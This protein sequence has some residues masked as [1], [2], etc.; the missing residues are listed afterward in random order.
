MQNAN[1]D[2]Q[3]A[4]EPALKPNSEL[5]RRAPALD[6]A[7]SETAPRSQREAV[8]PPQK[9]AAAKDA[10]ASR[11]SLFGDDAPPAT[12]PKSPPPASRDSLF[13][14]DVPAAAKPKPE[15]KESRDSLFGS[16]APAAAAPKPA[17]A[18]R[19]FV[20][21]EAAYGF[22]DPA[23]WTKE[24]LRLELNRQ[25]QFSENV[26]WKIGGRFDYDAA[27]D[28]SNFYAPQV[29]QDQRYGFTL[30]ENYLDISS[31]NLEMRLGR[32]HVVWG[33]VVGFFVADVVSAKDQREFIL[34]E[35]EFEMLRIPQWAAR[36]EYF[37]K[38]MKAEL[39][40]IPVPSFDEIG[41]PGIPGVRGAAGADFF[42]YPIPGPGGT[43]FLGEVLPSAKLANTNYGARM[44]TLKSGW[45][46]SA[47][48]YHSL[49]SAPTFYRNVI[50]GP[51]PV[52][53]YQARHDRINQFGGTFAKDLGNMV[54]K[55]EAVYTDGRQF[56]VTRI[57][58]PNGLV[59]QKTID[60]VLGLDFNLPA[61]ARLN[62]QFF[63][64]VFLDHDPDTLQ[65][66]Y[67]SGVSVLFDAVK[68]GKN[69]EGRALLIHSLNR[70]DWLLR[71]KVT[72]SFQK[73]WRWALGV[74]I[75]SGPPTGL[76]GRFD[77]NDRVYTELRYTF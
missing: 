31:G 63:Q 41:K 61:D 72:W 39:L 57:D 17:S 60:Y 49:D 67:E 43:A 58:Q 8:A 59:E 30:R 11:D 38:D 20:A 37:M 66:K 68:L 28:S 71:P 13:G 21:G 52:F 10:P 7:Q 36:A 69:L 34:P 24:R 53:V 44:S 55:G 19:G 2:M 25:G 3:G 5:Q 23:H 56:N 42:P 51:A 70:S 29:Q 14:D 54:L 9:Q 33:E 45:D 35:P 15:P 26:K 75:F 6:L 77:N 73:N 62:L 50:A 4:T 47:F 18:W 22:R 64:R 65:K 12:P 46:I 1:A 74:D 32:Q 40:W 76:F 48:Y 27:Y 16:D